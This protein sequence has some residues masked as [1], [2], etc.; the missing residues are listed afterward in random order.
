MDSPVLSR[1]RLAFLI[2]VLRPGRSC[3]MHPVGSGG[4]LTR[5]ATKV[6]RWQVVHVGT[7]FFIGLMG[8]AV[9]LLVRDLTGRPGCAGGAWAA[10]VFVLFYGAWEAV[11]GLAV[12]A[13]VQ[14][15]NGLPG[16]LSARSD[17]TPSRAST[18]TP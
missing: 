9:Y 5:S 2:G 1:Q 13:L 10:A 16:P 14:Y 7:L 8:L 11:A 17:R 18:T 3:S 15:T 6:T 4:C 12:G